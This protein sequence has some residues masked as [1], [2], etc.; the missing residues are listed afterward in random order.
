MFGAT[1]ADKQAIQWMIADAA[2]E[3]HAARLMVYHAATLKDKG[4]PFSKEAS[5]AKLFSSEMSERVCRNAVQILGGYGY[6]R[7]YPVERF[8]RDTRLMTIGE[9][10]SEVQRLIIS[11]MVLD[12]K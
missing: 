11:R 10:A 5:M 8:Y 7:E 4:K 9:G 2:T 12:G 3:I 6:S 1:L